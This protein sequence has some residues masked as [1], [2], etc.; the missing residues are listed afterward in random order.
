[1][2]SAAAE[3]NRE[4]ISKPTL[5]P[6]IALVQ[7]QQRQHNKQRR[8]LMELVSTSQALRFLLTILN[9]MLTKK[10]LHNTLK[11]LEKSMI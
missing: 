10:T 9:L 2:D 1:M 4:I 3:V 7:K 6:M 5:Q 11:C 8:H